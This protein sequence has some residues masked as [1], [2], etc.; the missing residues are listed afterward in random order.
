MN[1]VLTIHSEKTLAG[2]LP[3]IVK[4]V[5]SRVWKL[6]CFV[7]YCLFNGAMT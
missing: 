2:S 4:P 7:F 1:A 6:Y 5:V 3:V